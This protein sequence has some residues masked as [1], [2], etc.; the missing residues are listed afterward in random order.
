MTAVAH[1]PALGARVLRSAVRGAVLVGAAIVMGI[2]LLNVV[3]GVGSPGSSSRGAVPGT[4]AT[5]GGTTTTTT[6]KQL[7][8][9]V[10]NASGVSGAATAE[11]NKLR[12]LGYAILFTGNA[13]TPQTG[14]T[15]ACKADVS[16]TA[17]D[18]LTKAAAL[19]ATVA[20]FPSP[21]PT[22]A[23]SADCIVSVGK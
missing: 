5:T 3:N 19:G 14:T 1:A 23:V 17:R 11:A 2:I 20:P 7:K 9:V 16:V 22:T 8:L 4:T 13:T 18:T 15:V 10:F 21:V 12:G 6:G